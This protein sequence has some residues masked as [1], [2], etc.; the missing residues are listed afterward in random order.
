[1]NPVKKGE[2]VK[3]EGGK[4]WIKNPEGKTY[5]VPDEVYQVWASCDGK[6]SIEEIV[7]N[8]SGGEADEMIE[9]GIRRILEG[10][11][12]RGLVS[13]EEGED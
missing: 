2:V 13:L 8:F 12:E 10:L 5:K 9:K 6:T 7:M 3:V 1:M 11:G 4:Y